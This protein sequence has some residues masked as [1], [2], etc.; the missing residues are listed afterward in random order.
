VLGAVLAIG[1][2]SAVAAW[3]ARK[4]RSTVSLSP[5]ETAATPSALPAS[6]TPIAFSNDVLDTAL[7]DSLRQAFGVLSAEPPLSAADL[8]IIEQ[9]GAAVEHGVRERDDF[10]RR[11]M[12]LPKLMQL[13]NDSETPREALVRTILEDPAIAGGVLQQ[14]N[15]AYYRVSPA[16][17]DN[18]DRAVGLLGTDGI[19]R[20]MATAIMQPVF[21]APKGPFE[22][23]APATWDFAER[24]ALAIE[25]YSQGRQHY[26]HLVAQLLAVIGPLA[27][28]VTFRLTL[29][30]YGKSSHLTPR[31]AAFIR[32]IKR[33]AP[34]VALHIAHAWELSDAS[35]TALREQAERTPPPS[36]GELGRAVYYANLAAALAQVAARDPQLADQLQTAL[37]NQGLTRLE[38]ELLWN[39]AASHD[40]AERSPTH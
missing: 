19:R 16:R 7:S 4:R 5:S 10:P 18:I 12:L 29:D 2:G 1:A 17:I 33:F 13:L 26:D 21:R 20:L 3:Y 37:R 14:A 24:S 22:S 23:F 32:A 31:A 38:V 11:P 35:T 8:Q 25:A 36:M 6:S 9:V 28:I 15:S 30:A 40:D 27:R 34:R 39:A